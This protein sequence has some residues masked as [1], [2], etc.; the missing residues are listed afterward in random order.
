MYRRDIVMS[1]IVSS[2]EPLSFSYWADGEPSY[3]EG[4]LATEVCAVM[5][6]SEDWQ[7][8]DWHCGLLDWKFQFICQFGQFIFELSF[9]QMLQNNIS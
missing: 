8:Q 1:L 3:T 5:K 2:G 6:R 9:V 4:R 7:W